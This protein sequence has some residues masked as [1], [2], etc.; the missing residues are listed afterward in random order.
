MW[1]ERG[2]S[3]RIQYMNNTIEDYINGCNETQKQWLVKMLDYVREKHPNLQETISYQMPTFKW[4]KNY[5]S[6]SVATNHISLHSLDFELVVMAK[7]WFPKAKFGKGC[8]KVA[9]SDQE[10]LPELYKL[11]DRII[12]RSVMGKKGTK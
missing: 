5:I 7:E 12:E 4:N 2:D 6:F 3:D 1:G 8:V 9:Y 11:C 10:Y